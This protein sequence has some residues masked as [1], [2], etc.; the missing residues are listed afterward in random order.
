MLKHADLLQERMLLISLLHLIRLCF[1]S[2]LGN[3]Q[4]LDAAGHIQIAVGI[5]V[6]QVAGPE[7][8]I[9]SERLGSLVRQIVVAREDARPARQDFA[10]CS[11]FGFFLAFFLGKDCSID[12]NLDV[13]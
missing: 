11:L 8:A 5:D 4:R 13:R 9:A 6:T 7:P 10:F 2:P 12:A 1:L 3:D